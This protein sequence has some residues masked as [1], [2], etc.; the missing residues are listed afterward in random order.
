MEH[1]LLQFK[2]YLFAAKKLQYIVI[3]LVCRRK[4]V[5]YFQLVQL[6]IYSGEM[7]TRIYVLLLFLYLRLMFRYGYIGDHSPGKIGIIIVLYYSNTNI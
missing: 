1:Y 5:I 4:A 2:S 6:T 7:C 3:S